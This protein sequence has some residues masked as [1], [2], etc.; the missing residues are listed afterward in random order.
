ME[1]LP[2]IVVKLN[3]PSQVLGDQMPDKVRNFRLKI[4]P[5]C[6]RVKLAG[7]PDLRRAGKKFRNESFKNAQR[8]APVFQDSD[9]GEVLVHVLEWRVKHDHDWPGMEL[10]SWRRWR[11]VTAQLTMKFGYSPSSTVSLLFC[12]FRNTTV[13]QLRRYEPSSP[14]SCHAPI[15]G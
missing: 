9:D 11:L 8:F 15:S 1:P 5:V 10:F 2:A 7:A 14:L 13:Y 3:L 12:I 4:V 6:V